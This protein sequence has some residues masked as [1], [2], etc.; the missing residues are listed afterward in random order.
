MPLANRLCSRL[1]IYPGGFDS[2]KAHFLSL[3]PLLN[4]HK[5]VE[6]ILCI[7]FLILYLTKTGKCGIIAG[8]LPA[9]RPESSIISYP[10]YFVSGQNFHYTTATAFCQAKSCCYFAQIFIPKFVHFAYC[11]FSWFSVY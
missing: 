6:S 7:F 2:R 11:I 4:M 3:I 9:E 10:T 8:R 5:N 1:L